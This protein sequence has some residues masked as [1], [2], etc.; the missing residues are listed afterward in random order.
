LRLRRAW[1]ASKTA[2]QLSELDQPS[3]YAAVTRR[4]RRSE[5]LAVTLL[6]AVEA[7]KLW[8]AAGLL[9]MPVLATHTA[10]VYHPLIILCA[11]LSWF[12]VVVACARE[13]RKLGIRC[14]VA[15]AACTTGIQLESTSSEPAGAVASGTGASCIN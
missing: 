7:D 3:R 15:R 8:I 4:R 13:K 6:R 9:P 12:V 5:Q 2:L 14:V 1:I 10:R 11:E